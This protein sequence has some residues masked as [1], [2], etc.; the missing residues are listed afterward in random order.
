MKE[1]LV[2]GK[3]L[4]MVLFLRTNIKVKPD[5]GVAVKAFNLSI[6]ETKAGPFMNSDPL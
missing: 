3:F 6:R 5:W 2:S 4:M 1:A